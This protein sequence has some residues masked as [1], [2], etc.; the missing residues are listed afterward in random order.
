[1]LLKMP[2]LE[3]M[4]FGALDSKIEEQ[5]FAPKGASPMLQLAIEK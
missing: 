3:L 2:K 5:I 1:M 4:M